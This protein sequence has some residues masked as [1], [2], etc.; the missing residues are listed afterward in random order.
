MPQY[1]MHMVLKHIQVRVLTN[2]NEKTKELYK[3]SMLP[4]TCIDPTNNM[5]YASTYFSEEKFAELIVNECAKIC[6]NENVSA[7]SIDELNN[8]AFK[9]QDLATK[10]CGA[11]LSRI[12]K[13]RFGV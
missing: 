5:P 3:K 10:S 6:V 2:M 1:G 12:I 7:L 13:K 8:S 11:E 9:I 4:T